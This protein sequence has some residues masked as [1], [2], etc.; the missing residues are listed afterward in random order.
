M[1]EGSGAFLPPLHNITVSKVQNIG[2]EFVSLKQSIINDDART[3]FGYLAALNGR[4]HSFSFAIIE[5]V[6]RA[7]TKNH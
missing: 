7:I 4:I 2:V 5:V 6:Q 3:Q 1:F